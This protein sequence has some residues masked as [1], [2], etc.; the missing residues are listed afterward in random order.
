QRGTLAAEL[1]IILQQ[2]VDI[3]NSSHEG[4]YIFGGFKTKSAPFS[5]IDSNAD[6]KYES[7]AY[8]GGINE[9]ISRSL[10]PGVSIALN[11]DGKDTFEGLF[12]TIIAARDA[13]QTN[14]PA[15]IQ[16][17]IAP[18]ENAL[19]KVNKAMTTNGARQRQVR[20][21]KDRLEKAQTELKSL[22]SSKEDTNMTEAISYLQQQQTVYQTVLEVGQR[23]I[24]AMSLFNLLS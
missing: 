19:E 13:L 23:A 16:A 12:K 4:N 24:S 22:L 3:A 20:Q 1:D 11:I 17:A 10:S 9:T 8:N 7:V 2:A 14:D 6:G 21:A 5:L 18:L 15:Q